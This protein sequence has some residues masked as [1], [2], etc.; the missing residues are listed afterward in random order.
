[1]THGYRLFGLNIMSELPLPDLEPRQIGPSFDVA[2][3]GAAVPGC[4]EEPEGLYVRPEGAVLNIRGVGRYLVTGGNRISVEPDPAA[5][6]RNV[7]LYLL[8]SA[9]GAILHQRGLLPLHANV[10]DFDGTAV[11]FMGHS[12]AGKSTLAS[13]FHDRGY[14][15]VGDDVCVVTQDAEGHPVAELGLPRMRLWNDALAASGRKA[16]DYEASFDDMD[17]F[18][19]PTTNPRSP[20]LRRLGA[21]YDLRRAEPGSETAIERM[22]GIDAIQ[23]LVA[24]TYRGAFVPLLGEVKRHLDQCIRLSRQVPLFRLQRRWGFD[25]FDAEGERIEAHVREALRG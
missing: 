18:D 7:R 5:T 4:E 15:I 14:P 11:A 25:A 8:G 6:D 24:N 16:G 23:S 2:I 13:W 19:V 22:T 3:D 10:I 9:F 21:I 20:E 1:M 17:K 12:G